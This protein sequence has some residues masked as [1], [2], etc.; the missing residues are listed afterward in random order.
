MALLIPQMLK[1]GEWPG[2]MAHSPS[3]AETSQQNDVLVESTASQETGRL[4]LCQQTYISP[5]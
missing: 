4:F 2:W 1:W 3:A 5:P